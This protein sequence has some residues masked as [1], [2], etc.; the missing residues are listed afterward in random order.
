MTISSMSDTEFDAFLGASFRAAEREADHDK[1]RLDGEAFARRVAAR[2]ARADRRRFLVVGAA[3]SVGAVIAGARLPA[4]FERVDLP[5][6]N[7][8]YAALITPEALA[9]LCMAALVGGVALI[10]G[11]RV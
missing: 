8:A 7:P 4:L 3:A 5:A 6:I 10:A 2:L 1:A 9:A 11:R